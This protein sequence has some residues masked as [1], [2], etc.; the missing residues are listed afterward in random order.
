MSDDIRHESWVTSDMSKSLNDLEIYREAMRRG[1]IVWS[2][3]VNW[4]FLAKD[5]VGMQFVR[6][7]GFIAANIS[8]GHG[9][10]HHKEKQ[11]FCYYSWD[12]LVESLRKRLNASI[13][14]SGPQ[15]DT[16]DSCLMT[17]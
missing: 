11:K 9:R 5:T 7:I 14:S 6:S 17:H 2:W 12:S 13:K 16:H 3:V 15:S 10:F 1:E 8:K 4:D